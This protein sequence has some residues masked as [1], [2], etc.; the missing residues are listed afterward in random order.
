MKIVLTGGGSGGHVTPLMAVAAELKRREPAAKLIYVGQTGDRFAE[1]AAKHPAIDESYS[2]RAGKFRRYHG[3]G[4]HQLLD[5]KTMFLNLRDFFYVLTGLWQSRKLMKQ[6]QPDI[7]FSRGG[8]VSVPVCLGGRMVGVP[9]ITHDSDPVPSLAN[10]LIAR[11]ASVHAVAL[12]KDIYPYPANKTVTTGIPLSKDFV[13]VT[14]ALKKKYRGAAKIPESAQ[15]LF[16][17]G[18]G[19]GSQAINRAAG[20]ILPHLLGEF[21]KLYVIHVAGENNLAE[22][23]TLY[24]E[25]LSEAEQGRVR[26]IGYTDAVYRYSGAADIVVCRAGATNLAEFAVQ[27]KACVVVPSGVLTGGHQLRNAEYLARRNAAVVM[28][29]RELSADANRLA[30]RLSSLLSDPERRRQL[31]DNLAKFAKPDAAEEIADLILGKAGRSDV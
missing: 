26:L 16:I 19:Q 6:L 13:P 18:G 1:V 8:F 23:T 9:Y 12:P 28:D 20:D 25:R 10:R 31:G 2:V 3:E 7:I 14:E 4:W 15:A 24:D 30:K 27:G 29:D 5:L 11:W 21:P 22:M 17:I